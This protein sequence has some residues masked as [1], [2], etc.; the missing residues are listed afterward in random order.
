[1]GRHYSYSL[2]KTREIQLPLTLRETLEWFVSEG[3]T[4][5]V[6]W[7]EWENAE[8]QDV[9]IFGVD[10][11]SEGTPWR[12]AFNELHRLVVVHMRYNPQ[13]VVHYI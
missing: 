7:E 13:S 8:V 2:S 11:S 5:E 9:K 12:K 6:L 3:G 1:M 10:F 4:D